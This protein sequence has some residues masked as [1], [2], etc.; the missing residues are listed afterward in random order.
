MCF[1]IGGTLSI[2]VSVKN[3]MRLSVDDE[4]VLFTSFGGW[5]LFMMMKGCLTVG[6]I[7]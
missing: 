6:M 3:S 1:L 7:E 2:S 5:C 4:M